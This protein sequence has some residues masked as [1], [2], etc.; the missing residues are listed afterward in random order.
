MISS[1]F[2]DTTIFTC[3]YNYKT[4]YTQTSKLRHKTQGKKQ[5]TKKKLEDQAPLFFYV[6]ASIMHWLYATST[7]HISCLLGN[8]DARIGLLE[9]NP[10]L[11]RRDRLES[12]SVT[13]RTTAWW[14]YIQNDARGSRGFVLTTPSWRRTAGFVVIN[15][16]QRHNKAFSYHNHTTHLRSRYGS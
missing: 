16:D 14:W 6:H 7:T 15:A 11:S 8:F 9:T 5:K 3:E 13:P 1:T 4:S 12:I 2:L 10:S